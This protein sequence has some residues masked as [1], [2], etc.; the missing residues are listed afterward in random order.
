MEKIKCCKC[1]EEITGFIA[2]KDKEGTWCEDCINLFTC[3][4]CGNIENEILDGGLCQE[5]EQEDYSDAETD[6]FQDE[7]ELTTENKV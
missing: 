3:E 7:Y 6:D 2:Y 5:C 4:E 1:R